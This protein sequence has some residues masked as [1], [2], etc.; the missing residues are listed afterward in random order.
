M[1]SFRGLAHIVAFALSLAALAACGGAF[2]PLDGSTSR[3]DASMDAAIDVGTDTTDSPIPQNDVPLGPPV[4]SVPSCAAS[5][6]A[7]LPGAQRDDYACIA[8]GASVD[9][10]TG[11][12]PS[13]DGARLPLV[14][15][16]SDATPPGTGTML[17][18]FTTIADAVD[19]LQGVA[20]GP[21]G[22]GNGTVVLHRGDH[23]VASTILI[24]HDL[25]ILGVGGPMGSNVQPPA[26]VAVFEIATPGISLT[27]TGVN[28][29]KDTPHR[30][31]MLRLVNGT[32]VVRDVDIE[33]SQVGIEA[34]AG[35][36]DAQGLTVNGGSGNAISLGASGDALIR[37]LLVHGS[38]VGVRS[39]GA[40]LDLSLALVTNA[41][42]AGVSVSA[43]MVATTARLDRVAVIRAGSVGIRLAGQGLMATATRL[44]LAGTRRDVAS[45][46]SGTGLLVTGTGTRFSLDPDIISD[47][48]QG[49]GSR[50][51]ANEGSGIV[52]ADHAH[53]TMH[54]AFISS[55]GQ[56][57][58]VIQTSAV[59]D[60]VR[61]SWFTGNL[62]T[63]LMVST[64]GQLAGLVCDGFVGNLRGT[65]NFSGATQMQMADGAN[66]DPGTPGAVLLVSG[67]TF[68]GHAGFGLFCNGV[69][70]MLI[71]D[72]FDGNAYGWG[73][74][75]S[76]QPTEVGV[77]NRDSQQPPD[78]GGSITSAGLSG[79][80]ETAPEP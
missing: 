39:V 63:G 72:T 43:G 35:H 17:S 8:V 69:Q 6:E 23:V 47:R 40:A 79:A 27:V 80:V 48:L 65:M 54:G 37:S 68:T 52:I 10:T 62:G 67:C 77:N 64:S 51:G 34:L 70:T 33:M 1:I 41:M 15:V 73:A 57:G 18:P 59:V 28:F 66:I 14:F 16:R 21:P 9:I 53:A 31:P 3:S 30:G 38:D 24:S 71:N 49:L 5:N 13:L 26:N 22:L 44:M 19:A 12:W 74:Y 32:L 61:Y 7:P 50:I 58:I 4:F 78:A 46:G 11:E 42:K 36:L 60:E 75:N 55:N 76:S 25:A 45:V 20:G 29:N 2:A 56:S